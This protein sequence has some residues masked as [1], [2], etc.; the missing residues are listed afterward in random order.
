MIEIYYLDT[1]TINQ[2]TYEI[3]L[4]K[5]PEKIQKEILRY[6]YLKDQKFKF[7]GKLMIKEYCFQKNIDFDW[8]NWQV[9]KYGKP[10]IKNMPHFNISHSGNYVIVGFSESNIGIDIELMDNKNIDS[11]IP[12]FHPNEQKF[13]NDSPDKK[14]AF[15]EIWTRKEAFL[16][17]K[18]IGIT[19][20]LRKGDLSKSKV[21]ENKD[22]HIKTFDLLENYK[23]SICCNQIH[24]TKIY[25]QDFN[26][27]FH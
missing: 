4:C 21:L 17:A 8:N 3:N 12:L 26:N 15:Y 16:K 11:F 1:N 24:K 7:F 2:K 22:W 27:I 23:I 14:N 5:I 25:W 10:F 20:G 13:I 6:K 9:T 19:K 18:G